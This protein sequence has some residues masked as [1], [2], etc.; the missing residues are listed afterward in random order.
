M[1][2]CSK[3]GRFVSPKANGWHF[4]WTET[5]RS[6]LATRRMREIISRNWFAQHIKTG[7]IE[8]SFKL[9]NEY[10]ASS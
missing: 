8:R 1:L 3:C 7:D 6:R 10:Y 2:R 4:C 9:L 5:P